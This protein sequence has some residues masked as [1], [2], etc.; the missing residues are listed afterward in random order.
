MAQHNDNCFL[1]SCSRYA[2]YPTNIISRVSSNGKVKEWQSKLND[3][4]IRS[5]LFDATSAPC[6]NFLDLHDGEHGM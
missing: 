5:R 4:E 6:L 3:P 2:D 1:E